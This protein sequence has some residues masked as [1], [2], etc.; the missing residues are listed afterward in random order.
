MSPEAQRIA[1]AE[2]CPSIRWFEL[3][4]CWYSER[5]GGWIPCLNNDPLTDLNAMNEA[6]RALPSHLYWTFVEWCG[7]VART[8]R[9]DYVADRASATVSTRAEVFLRT[10]NLWDDTK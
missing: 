6:E 4:W 7:V 9:A 3:R 2:A 8:D 10:L 5:V 1:I